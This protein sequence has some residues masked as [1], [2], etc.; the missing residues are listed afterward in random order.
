MCIGLGRKT[1]RK[2][3]KTWFIL[4][5]YLENHLTLR[6]DNHAGVGDFRNPK[7]GDREYGMELSRASN[8]PDKQQTPENNWQ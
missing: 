3:V 2:A 1:K 5:L 7:P 6:G 4:I 8:C